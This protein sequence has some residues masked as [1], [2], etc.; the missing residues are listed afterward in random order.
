MSD[1]RQMFYMLANVH[2]QIVT[3]EVLLPPDRFWYYLP[4]LP[5]GIQNAAA[6]FQLELEHLISHEAS[7]S[8]ILSSAAGTDVPSL[9]AFLVV[10]SRN[11]PEYDSD[12]IDYDALPRMCYHVD[13]DDLAEEVP[14]LTPRYQ[15]PHSRTAYLQEKADRLRAR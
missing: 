12:D 5:F 15:S 9:C 1:R 14:G 3:C 8:I 11:G 10:L 4:D 2:H 6:S 13:G 7:W